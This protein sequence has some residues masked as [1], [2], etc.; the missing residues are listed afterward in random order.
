MHGKGHGSPVRGIH[1]VDTAQIP[2][3]TWQQRNTYSIILFI[4]KR[5]ETLGCATRTNLQ[6]AVLSER[7]QTHK[8]I[9]HMNLFIPN[10]QSQFICRHRCKPVITVWRREETRRHCLMRKRFY[11]VVMEIFYS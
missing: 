11:F 3:N 6:N 7:S 9:Y 10:I 1:R 8:V 4:Q 2:I 5:D